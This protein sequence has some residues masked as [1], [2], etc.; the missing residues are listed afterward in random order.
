MSSK[1]IGHDDLDDCLLKMDPEHKIMTRVEGHENTVRKA[2]SASVS[3][4]KL[5]YNGGQP[6][7]P[8]DFGDV[9]ARP[10]LVQQMRT[11]AGEMGEGARDKAFGMLRARMIERHAE[12]I[13][14]GRTLACVLE[15][16]DIGHVL[17]TVLADKME[18]G[19]PVR[20]TGQCHSTCSVWNFRLLWCPNMSCQPTSIQSDPVPPNQRSRW[21]VPRSPYRGPPPQRVLKPLTIPRELV[22]RPVTKGLCSC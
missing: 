7:V 16:R 14:L 8:E 10:G 1:E 15:S 12:D 4:G 11:L 21:D 9:L 2:T 6:Y 13:A 3:L 17:D 5:W 19:I 22:R 20:Q 18:R